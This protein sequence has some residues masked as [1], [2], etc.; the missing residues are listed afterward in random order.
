MVA[1]PYMAVLEGDSAEHYLNQRR[2]TLT[3]RELTEWD[4]AYE[5][6]ELQGTLFVA[7]P[8]HCCVG[9]KV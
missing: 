5:G 8:F 4:R 1:F 3:P 6:A 7:H 2:D 9:T